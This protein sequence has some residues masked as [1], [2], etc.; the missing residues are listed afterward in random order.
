MVEYGTGSMMV[1]GNSIGGNVD[2]SDG[3]QLR[4]LKKKWKGTW[5]ANTRMR[6]TEREQDV[7][8]MGGARGRAATL[9][10]VQETITCNSDWHTR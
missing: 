1:D 8:L 3:R 10:Y 7:E 5:G 6:A 2:N 4:T 9:I